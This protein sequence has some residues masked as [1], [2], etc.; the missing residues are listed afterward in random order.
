MSTLEIAFASWLSFLFDL[1]VDDSI[2]LNPPATEEEIHRLETVI[3]QELPDELRQLYLIANGQRDPYLVTPKPEEY[4]ASLFLYYEFLPIE[5]VIAQYQSWQNIIEDIGEDG[6][7]F[8]FA[9]EGHPVDPVYWSASWIPVAGG[10]ANGYAI[11]LSPPRGGNIGQVINFGA[12][13]DARIVIASS[14]SEFFQMAVQNTVINDCTLRY[15][16]EDNS[17]DHVPEEYRVARNDFILEFAVDWLFPENES[18]CVEPIVYQQPDYINET[19][20]IIE[21]FRLSMEA[22][23]EDSDHT[24]ELIQAVNIPFTLMLEIKA[25]PASFKQLMNEG[26]KQELPTGQLP[27]WYAPGSRIPQELVDADPSLLLEFPG[28]T[29]PDEYRYMEAIGFHIYFSAITF[30]LACGD[31]MSNLEDIQL[32]ASDYRKFHQHLVL[33]GLITDQQYHH[34]D[35]AMDNFP[36]VDIEITEGFSSCSLQRVK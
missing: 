1:R 29:I 5:G 23:G 10:G 22:T 13:D 34:L 8:I 7:E 19:N 35:E 31:V 26:W 14:L 3:G 16:V 24:D 25:R 18:L 36:S 17:D 12:D 9:A 32:D 20:A 28:D 21:R 27:E 11:D 6:N 2:T 4:S 30:N 15:G 33:E